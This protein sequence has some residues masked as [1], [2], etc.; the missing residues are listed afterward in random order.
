MG[1]GVAVGVAVDVAVAVGVGV[2]VPPAGAWIATII[3]EPVLKNPTVALAF[4]FVAKVS[5]LQII[6]PTL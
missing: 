2:G 4:W 1:R 5:V 3:G 6:A